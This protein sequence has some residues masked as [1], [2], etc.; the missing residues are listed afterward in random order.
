MI[1][2]H[3]MIRPIFLLFISILMAACTSID[4][5]NS[6]I[7]WQQQQLLLEQ[8]ERY[9]ISGKLGYKDPEQRHTF[10]FL[11]RHTPAESQLTLTT[12]LGQSVLKI[13]MDNNGATVKTREGDIYKGDDASQLIFNLTKLSIPIEHLSDWMK[14]LP[15]AADSYTL[16]SD[17]IV[18]HLNKTYNQMRW[19]LDYQAYAV[20]DT[21]LLPQKMQ[22]Q[23]Q[24]TSLKIVISNWTIDQ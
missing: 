7:D 14:G 13:T 15:T 11:W 21:L 4:S 5:K 8:L 16:N 2:A 6:N 1:S 22:L 12:F 9:Q 3:K 19:Q 20:S 17:N 23:Q 24:D 10:N 18:K